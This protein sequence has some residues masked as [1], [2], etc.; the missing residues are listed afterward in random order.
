MPQAACSLLEGNGELETGWAGARG[1]AVEVLQ[2][3]LSQVIPEATRAMEAENAWA[4]LREPES[5]L[6]GIASLAKA[7]AD[8]KNPLLDKILRHLLPLLRSSQGASRE[9]VL[10][11]C[12]ELPGH[13]YVL[14]RPE[15]LRRLLQLWLAASREGEATVRSLSVRGL[16]NVAEGAPQEAK[17]HQE[18]LLA[19]LLQGLGDPASPEVARESLHALGKVWGCLGRR[20]AGRMHQAVA[21]QACEYLWHVSQRE[22][23]ARAGWSFLE[24]DGTTPCLRETLE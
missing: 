5:R 23:R 8:T 6:K 19:A 10:A 24:Q 12:V 11:F 13:P 2:T 9:L 17:K 14:R 21:S 22:Q 15:I 4:L 3:T 18:D 16:G 20:H 1:L 7:L